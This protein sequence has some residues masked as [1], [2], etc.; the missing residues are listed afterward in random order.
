MEQSVEWAILQI[1]DQNSNCYG[2]VVDTTVCHSEF[3]G[4]YYVEV[5]YTVCNG[6]IRGQFPVHAFRETLC[7]VLDRMSK[8]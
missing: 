7:S 1:R 4:G 5:V 3:N 8:A 2:V 6:R